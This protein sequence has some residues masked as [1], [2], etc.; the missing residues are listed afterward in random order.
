[1]FNKIVAMIVDKLVDKLVVIVSKKL[2]LE[3]AV[4]GM[5]REAKE[6]QEEVDNANTDEE[7]RAVLRKISNLHK[8][9][10]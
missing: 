7:R 3:M 5:S 2:E 4:I 8:Y 9:K 10:L 6:L 1:M